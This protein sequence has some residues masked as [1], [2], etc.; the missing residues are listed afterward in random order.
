[1]AVAG[2][3]L[4]SA[5][6]FLYGFVRNEAVLSSQI[7]GAQATLQDV[8]TYEATD[9]ALRPDDVRGVC[10]YVEARMCAGRRLASSQ[11]LPLSV[12][13]IRE[14]HRRLMKGARGAGQE[15]GRLRR[16]QNWIGGT[17]PGN[18]AQRLGGAV[19]GNAEG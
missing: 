10:H 12:R 8:L 9:R 1:M 19:E 2:A 18:S 11:G 3:M 13:L 7:E 16:T 5:D 17:R 15:P 14:T 4:P 6:W